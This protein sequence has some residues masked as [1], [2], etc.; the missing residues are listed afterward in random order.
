M[1]IDPDHLSQLVLNLVRNALEASTGSGRVRVTLQ[2]MQGDLGDVVALHVEDDGRGLEPAQRARMF[3]PFFTTRGEHG[4]TGLGLAIVRTLA[5]RYAGRA[6]ASST[7]GKGTRVTVEIP[8]RRTEGE[9][10]A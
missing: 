8:L 6:S 1:M 7:P 5:E 9:G 4:G 3:E 10:P 2:E